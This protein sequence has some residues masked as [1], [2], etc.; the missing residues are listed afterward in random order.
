[1]GVP[2]TMQLPAAFPSAEQVGGVTVS[3]AAAAWV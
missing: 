3:H 2:Q 1:M